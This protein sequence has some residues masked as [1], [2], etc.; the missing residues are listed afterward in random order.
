MEEKPSCSAVIGPPSL[1]P[2]IDTVPSAG[3]NRWLLLAT[4]IEHLLPTRLWAGAEA[5]NSGADMTSPPRVTQRDLCPGFDGSFIV[6][7]S[8]FSRSWLHTPL[9]PKHLSLLI[10][11][12]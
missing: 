3:I 9:S 2:A 8:P 7:C 12:P 4:P 5:Y 1:L 11:S 10:W 6:S